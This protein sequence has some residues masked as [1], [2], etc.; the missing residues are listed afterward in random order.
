MKIA[1]VRFDEKNEK[2]ALLR[3][4][5]RETLQIFSGILASLVISIYEVLTKSD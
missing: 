5:S 2:E 3:R 4:G 1:K